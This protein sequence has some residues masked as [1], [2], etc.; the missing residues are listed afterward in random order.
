MC[1]SWRHCLGIVR[2]IWASA[3]TGTT[4]H[5]PGFQ[6][7]PSKHMGISL[8]IILGFHWSVAW[9][10][11]VC[12]ATLRSGQGSRNMPHVPELPRKPGTH[13][14]AQHQALVIRHLCIRYQQRW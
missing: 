5:R 11:S 8:D 10:V 6:Q 9:V 3:T 14:P 4:F 12:P 2:R 13:F 7:R 1:T